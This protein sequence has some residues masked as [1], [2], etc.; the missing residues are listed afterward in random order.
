MTN[1]EDIIYPKAPRFFPTSGQWTV[2]SEGSSVVSGLNHII[3]RAVLHDENMYPEPLRFN[4]DRFAD[5]KR[6][7]QLG[8]N[9]LPMAAF[10]F[11]RR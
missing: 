11:G 7:Q 8:I 10:G 4:P 2:C 1:T 5:E 6:N 3:L 9:E